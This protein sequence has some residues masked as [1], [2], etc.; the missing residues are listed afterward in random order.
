[1]NGVS[2]HCAK[3]LGCDLS[4]F[5]EE[6]GKDCKSDVKKGDKV[7]GVCHCANLVSYSM[8]QREQK[9]LIVT[10]RCWAWLICRV[11]FGQRWAYR[12][13]PW[14]SYLRRSRYTRYWCLIRWAVIVY[15][16]KASTAHCTCWESLLDS[17]LWRKQWHRNSSDSICETV[18]DYAASCTESMLI[19]CL[20]RAWKSS[21]LQAHITLI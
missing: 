18:R 17:D 10:E 20:V 8:W 2:F 19:F 12:K 7:Y 3:I 5:V 4:G 16:F 14:P 9:V 11:C 6:V 13:D 15:D 21:P 1:M